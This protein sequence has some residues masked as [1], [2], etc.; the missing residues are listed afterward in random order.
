MHVGFPRQM[1]FHFHCGLS[2]LD[3]SYCLM[4]LRVTNS[5]PAFILIR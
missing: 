4:N 3:A 5:S 1:L 2:Y